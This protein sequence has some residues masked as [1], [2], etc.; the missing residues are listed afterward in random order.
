VLF[1]FKLLIISERN[2]QGRRGKATELL[3][4]SQLF[5]LKV[6]FHRENM[7]NKCNNNLSISC[8]P[9]RKI[10]YTIINGHMKD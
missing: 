9:N 3:F 10:T 1:T 2:D 7:D 6:P 4:N 8:F 5:A